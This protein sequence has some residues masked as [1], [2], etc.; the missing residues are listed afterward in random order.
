MSK[1]NS[2]PARSYPF[3][4]KAQVA[5]RIA[6]D[7]D[8]ALM[9]IVIL[10]DRTAAR[11]PGSKAQ[12]FMSSHEVRGTALASKVAAGASLDAEDLAKA[13]EIASHYTKQISASLREEA[14][15]SSP[16]LVE[17]ARLYGV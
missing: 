17:V 15:A 2:S 16:E 10:A 14:K 8:F 13:A 1:K 6:S 5:E 7:P 4:T 3:I 9:A 12:G 11:Q